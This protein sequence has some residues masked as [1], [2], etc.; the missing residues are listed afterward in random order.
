MDEETLK[1]IASQL[2]MP[3]GH[4]GKQ[5]GEK[6]NAGNVHINNSA[7]EMLQLMPFNTVLE[8]GMGNGYFVKDI[9]SVDPSIRYTGCDFSELMVE[10]A[11]KLNEKF[12][13]AGQVE[14]HVA[15]ADK[16]P[17][18]DEVFDKVLTV[19]TLYFWDEPEVVLSE[20]KRVLK[21]KGQIVIAVRPKS[22]M[23]KYP[24]V[25]YGFNTFSKSDLINLLSKNHFEVIS[26]LEKEEPEQEV[27]GEMVKVETLIVCG[28][29]E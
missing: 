19:N 13:K 26:I 5:V 17:A 21:K 16:V 28:Q 12:I 10:E 7:I 27:N 11:R 9:V 24:F 15:S 29:K 20:I 1:A 3:Q 4:Y 8:I 25:K 14:F 2:R 18:A 22:V 23:V 6:M